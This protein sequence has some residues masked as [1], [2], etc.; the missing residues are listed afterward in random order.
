MITREQAMTMLAKA[1]K[2]AGMDV[3][4][5]QEEI[6]NQLELFK[7]SANISSYA[8]EGAAIC[9]KNGI[10]GGNKGNITPKNSF[11]RAES[12]TVVINL[13]R[14]AKLI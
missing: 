12:A 8:K 9:I 1:M 6:V 11:T 14:K 13:L 2:I 3:S 10:F 4:V 7:D 5:S